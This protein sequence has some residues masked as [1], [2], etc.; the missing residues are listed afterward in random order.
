MADHRV[1]VLS[2]F[3]QL[4]KIK[5]FQGRAENLVRLGYAAGV[6][7]GC[8]MIP[9]LRR[10]AQHTLALPPKQGVFLPVIANLC[11]E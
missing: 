11:C 8:L 6:F 3:S 2:N 5:E 1:C 7:L 10:D 9:P 4:K